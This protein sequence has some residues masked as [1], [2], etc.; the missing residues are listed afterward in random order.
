MMEQNNEAIT[1]IIG[2]VLVVLPLACITMVILISI[3]VDCGLWKRLSRL[4][5]SKSSKKKTAGGSSTQVTPVNS[6]E[7]AT[8]SATQSETKTTIKTTTKT[9]TENKSKVV[10]ASPLLPITND[11]MANDEFKNWNKKSNN[12]ESIWT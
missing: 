10:P 11:Q 5:R 9:A 8:R 7:T 4:C 12:E 2:Y 6:I 3:F 1:K